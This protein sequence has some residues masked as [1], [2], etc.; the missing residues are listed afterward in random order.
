MVVEQHRAIAINR[1]WRTV[2]TPK[3]VLLMIESGVLMGILSLAF[4]VG[5][6]ANTIEAHAK[7]LVI[8]RAEHDVLAKD[9]VETQKDI[10]KRLTRIETLMEK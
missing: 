3:H 10:I 7:E 1:G 8:L 9:L 5:I 6:Q 4:W 2:M